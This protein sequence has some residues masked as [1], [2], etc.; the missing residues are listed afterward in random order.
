MSFLWAALLVIILFLCWVLTLLSM[1]GNWLMV[2]AVIG[3]AFLVPEDSAVSI[4]WGTAI[5]VLVLAALGELLE[6]L[7]GALGV[8]KAGG[9]R[10]GAVLALVGSLAGGLVGLFVGLP[11]P[12][13]GSLLG[14][15]LFAG[16]GAFVGAVLG[17]QWKG[18]SFDDSCKIGEAAFWGRLLGTVAKAA[19][20]AVMV[21]TTLVALAV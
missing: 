3:Y 16:A 10:R 6:F 17:E 8:T 12:I 2:G 11:I 18:R 20:G 21:A 19:M 13:V 5:A 1:P 9:S 15:V 4:G 7:A 14:A